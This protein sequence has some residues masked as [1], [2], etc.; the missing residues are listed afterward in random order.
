MYI[1]K[2]NHL[3]N[4]IIQRLFE[5]INKKGCKSSFLDEKVLKVKDEHQINLESN[6]YLTEIA[7][8]GILIDNQGYQ[9]NIELLGAKELA[10]ILD[11]YLVN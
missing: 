9:Y 3:E 11:S 5:L 4:E 2:V 1:D 8:S 6:R 7:E 10:E